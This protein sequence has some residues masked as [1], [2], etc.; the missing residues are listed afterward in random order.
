MATTQFAPAAGG[1]PGQLDRWPVA[2]CWLTVLLDGL[3][4]VMLGAVIP[5]LL[6]SQHLGFTVAGATSVATASLVGVAIGAALVGSLAD[7]VGRRVVLLGSILLFS[8]FTLAIPFATSVAMFAGFRAI[9][10]VGL[11][12]CLPVALTFMSEHMPDEN[13]SHASTLTMTG[14]HVGAV[15]ASLVAIAV[16]PAWHIL[17]YLGGIAGLLL[18]PLVWFKLPESHAFLAAQQ[19]DDGQKVSIL[20]P[21]LMRAN[22]GVWVGCFMGLLLVYGL[23]TWLPQLMQKAG[24]S[25]S[26]S[27]VMLFILN[28]GAVVGLLV[29]GKLADRRGV[30]STILI[31]F[32]AAAVLLAALSIKMSSTVA[33]NVVVLV[34]GIFVFSAQVL[35][36]AY[37]THA[38]PAEVR[39][40]AM[41]LAA[42]I[43]RLGAIVGPLVTGALV[44][45]GLAYP[46]GFY[47]FAGVAVLGLLA[48]FTLPHEQDLARL[49]ISDDE[50]LTHQG[51]PA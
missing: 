34:T 6:K 44:N 10:G 23:N 33:L 16:V 4:L 39:S 20:H 42:G 15:I 9:A 30:R 14:Y 22:V 43:G 46:W 2:L 31:W 38:F 12:A 45:A 47:F 5:T 25:M 18:L 26:G 51:A 7:R 8:I 35:I 21:R 40:T 28:L 48:I 41:G 36:Y 3:D 29:A 19:K 13:R 27:L 24:Y 32:A 37:V 17:F 49:H 1:T 11:G 50:T